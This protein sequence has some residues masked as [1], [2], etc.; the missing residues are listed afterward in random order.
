VWLPAANGNVTRDPAHFPPLRI[1]Q[2]YFPLPWLMARKA[3][4]SSHH[5]W[6]RMLAFHV[7]K[8]W[9]S[10][11]HARDANAL[12][13]IAMHISPAKRSNE[14]PAASKERSLNVGRKNTAKRGIGRGSFT[15]TK[16]KRET[17]T[18]AL[19]DELY[20]NGPFPEALPQ[21]DAGGLLMRAHF[22]AERA[23]HPKAWL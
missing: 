21:L 12:K 20:P 16:L 8:L 18:E 5:G 4:Q 19:L 6:T 14:I 23:L 1:V 7:I 11:A 22:K 17:I 9:S 13:A 2:Q 15:N 10:R 3:L